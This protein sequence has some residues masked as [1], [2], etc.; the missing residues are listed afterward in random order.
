MTNIAEL[1]TAAQALRPFIVP[2]S[3]KFTFLAVLTFVALFRCGTGS[4]CRHQTVM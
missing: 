2:A 4:D 3:R 1:Q